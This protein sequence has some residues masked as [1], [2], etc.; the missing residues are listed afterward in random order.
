MLARWKLGDGETLTIALNL[1]DKPVALASP[2]AKVIFET[3]ARAQDRTGELGGHTCLAWLT[4]D[5]NLKANEAHRAQGSR[6]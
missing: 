3:P 1:D 4:G 6:S 5:V 2:P